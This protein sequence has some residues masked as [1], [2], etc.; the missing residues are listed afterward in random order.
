MQSQEFNINDLVQE[1]QVRWLKPA[2]VL[3][4]LQNHESHQLTEAPP[5]KPSSGSMFLFNKRVLRFFR[6]DGHDWRKKK[7][8]KTVGEAHERLKVG[9]VE[10]L[11]CYYA[12][13]EQNP[14][15]QRR[16]YWIL[17]PAHEHIVLVHYREIT[18]GNPGTKSTSYRS[19]GSFSTLSQSPTLCTVQNPASNSAVS[20]FYE[21]YRSSFS[22]GSMEVSSKLMVG[23][24]GIE[25][26]DEYRSEICSSS[27]EM[28]VN[29][30]LRKLKEQ[31]SL[32]DDD[33]AEVFPYFGEKENS[34]EVL[35]SERRPTQEILAG[36]EQLKN[37][38]SQFV[39]PSPNSTT[40]FL[41]PTTEN[42]CASSSSMSLLHEVDNFGVST[43]SSGFSVSEA[44][45]D[46]YSTWLDQKTQV[47]NPLGAVSNLTLGQ[48]QRFTIRE[49]SP[50]W[51]Y[52]TEHTK[53]IIIGSFLCNPSECTWSCMFG[54][55]EVPVHIIQ[56][57]IL[58]C[59]APPNVL[60][61]VTIC[62]TSSNRVSCSE[63]RE[64]EYRDKS[65]SYAPCSMQQRDGTK[66]TDELLLLVR[67]VQILMFDQKLHR[68][69][70]V[71]ML[72]VTKVDED[73]LGHMIETLLDG[74]ETTYSTIDQI[75]QVLLKDKLQQ[76]LSSK[77]QG[78]AV[79]SCYLS[80]KEQGIIHLAAGLGFEW[81]LN[82]VLNC[83]VSINFRDINGWT[84]L[85]WAARFGREKMVAAFIAGG[86]S[87]AAVTDPTA[88]D[89]A[90]KTPASV[91][92][93]YG[94][95]G[96]A[97]YL[98][99]VALTSHLSSLTIEES[100]ISK[101]FAAVEP[102]RTVESISREGFYSTEDQLSL[103]DSLAAVRNA[104]QAAARIQSAF[105]AHS[106]RRRQEEEAGVCN[107]DEYA[108][109][110]D[111]INGISAASKLVF[112]GHRDHKF[113]KEAL[114]IQK[115]Y[116]GW[117]ERKDFL[118]LRQKVV[119]IQA[120][121]R[122]HQVRKKYGVI[123]WAVNILDKVVLRW[124]RRGAGLR[125]YRPESESIDEREDEDILKVFRK[126][127]V[128]V[129]IEGA[130][131]Q[132]LSMVE[133]PEARMQY[134]RMLES[135]RQAKAELICNTSEAALISRG[136]SDSME[137]DNNVYFQFQ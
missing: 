132:V 19:P 28:E 16:C 116:R 4:I 63:V 26:S 89:P 53:V 7:D 44:K 121:V 124:R 81:A 72:R 126:Q 88:L 133:S 2:E 39:Y 35:D 104:T 131:S 96:L 59:R 41:Y 114:S 68:E 27:P 34:V 97:G 12:H 107:Y 22:P 84:A 83:G 99:E 78:G 21:P 65:K 117:K 128:E 30:A 95:G 77:Y 11:N 23:N 136:G 75:L 54:D 58:S 103:K 47:S 55:I 92:A 43:H 119:R 38:Y 5:Q 70:F 69:D 40:D 61:N 48:K 106:F 1:A 9:Y 6:K 74:S 90:G 10:A 13:G 20:E 100:E 42:S 71:D 111:E 85:H 29:Q 18:E 79:Q 93:D 49:V 135:Y 105:R 60:G 76:W 86:A 31:L 91:A 52:A 101:G 14:N 46:Y 73:P 118:T 51:G 32:N 37:W 62:I 25:Y 24:N 45:P 98:S 3:F 110:Q 50:E 17:D 122:G 134:R 113:D 127:N 67:F 112:R 8:G 87:A 129:A 115:K 82:P 137:N 64:F 94:Y 109:S 108:I 120:H 57:G 33:V 125:G 56:E 80:K 123:L 66:S 130:V 15:F 36:P 102:E